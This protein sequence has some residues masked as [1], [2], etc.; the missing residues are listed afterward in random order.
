MNAN[1][2]SPIEA[3]SQPPIMDKAQQVEAILQASAG[4]LSDNVE[5]K[6]K[7][8]GITDNESKGKARQ[9]ALTIYQTFM[10]KRLGPQ[11]LHIGLLTEENWSVLLTGFRESVEKNAKSAQTDQ[12]G[13]GNAIM[14]EYVP[15]ALEGAA[16]ARRTL[17]QVAAVQVRSG[18]D[19]AFEK[20]RGES[21]S[22]PVPWLRKLWPKK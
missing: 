18:V 5:R 6:L 21:T 16:C 22:K 11:D 9:T 19:S 7:E 17:L 20:F 13:A 1:P 8:L 2:N 12:T 14:M 4:E 3:D 10:E 15:F